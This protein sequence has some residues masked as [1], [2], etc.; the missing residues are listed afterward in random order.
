M[1]PGT[2]PNLHALNNPYV[3]AQCEKEHQLT[4]SQV[5]RPN[6]ASSLAGLAH[7][8]PCLPLGG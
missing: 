1:P 4:A 6:T 5:A 2:E 8:V 3:A 7:Q